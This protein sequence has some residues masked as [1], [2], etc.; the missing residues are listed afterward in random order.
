MFTQ[1]NVKTVLF[2]TIQFS[3]STQFSSIW[4]ID[5]TLSGATT[6]GQSG[7]GSDGNE[8]ILH[9]PQSFSITGVSP[10]DCLESYPGHLLEGVLLFCKEAVSVF[11]CPS[12]HGQLRSVCDLKAIQMNMQQSLIWEHALQVWAES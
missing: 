2:L 6:L 9:I 3:I 4:L 8:G 12:R 7:P 11:Y 10:S 1:S 5:R